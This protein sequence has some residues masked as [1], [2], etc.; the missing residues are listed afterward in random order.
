METTNKID[1]KKILDE[2]FMKKYSNS[3]GKAQ[4]VR[5]SIFD[6]YQILFNKEKIGLNQEEKNIVKYLII[7]G[8]P[9]VCRIKIWILCSGAQ[10]ELNLHPTYYNDLLKL[11]K[12]IPS[13]YTKEIEKDIDRTNKELLSKNS[14]FKSML[15]NILIC[16]SIRN[17]SIGYCQGFNFIALQIIEV[18]K[19]EVSYNFI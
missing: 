14:T 5:N 6:K 11:S 9:E 13:L 19:N 4:T 18:I 2:P 12:E 17:S 8:S 1:S 15:Y 16:Y 10:E 7:K 3:L